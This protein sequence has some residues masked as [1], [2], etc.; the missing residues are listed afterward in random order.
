M[1]LILRE[2]VLAEML[3]MDEAS[4]ALGEV[5]L[6]PYDSAISQSGCL[7]YTTLFDENASCHLAL[8]SA[9]PACLEGGIA[10]SEEELKDKGINV[11]LIHVDF[12]FGTADMDVKGE[13]APGTWVPIFQNGNFVL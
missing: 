6:V 12:M 7:F 13:S 11:S 2:E 9:Y 10:M 4:T 5:A 1:K 8:G 3:A